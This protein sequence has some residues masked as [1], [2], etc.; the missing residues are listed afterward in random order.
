MTY[1]SSRYAAINIV[2]EN[3]NASAFKYMTDVQ[4]ETFMY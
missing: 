4:S 2:H 1:L 3:P